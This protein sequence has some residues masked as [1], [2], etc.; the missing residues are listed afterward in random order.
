MPSSSNSA[1]SAVHSLKVARVVDSLLTHTR[2]V[3][4]NG[5]DGIPRAV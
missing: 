2:E 5:T 4:Y 1:F 3:G